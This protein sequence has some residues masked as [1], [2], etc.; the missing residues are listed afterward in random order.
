MPLLAADPV[1]VSSSVKKSTCIWPEQ[2]GT[3]KLIAYLTENCCRGAQE[4]CPP[5]AVCK[6]ARK[7]PAKVAV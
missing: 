7:K 3:A 4:A 6:P 1:I 2:R 5:A